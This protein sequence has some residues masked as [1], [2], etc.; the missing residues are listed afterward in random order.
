MKFY[1]LPQYAGVAR[2]SVLPKPIADDDSRWAAGFFFLFLEGP[3][4]FGRQ[5]D[6]LEKLFR[7]TGARDSLGLPS[8]NT[9]QVS[10]LAPGDGE[11]F[12]DVVIAFPILIVRQRNR[13]FLTIGRF[14]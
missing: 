8:R 5:P 3:S 6:D 1:G 2:E 13:K 4:Q 12:K 14:V 10:R 9:A 11:I 7:D